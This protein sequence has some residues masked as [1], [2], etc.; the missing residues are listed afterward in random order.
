MQIVSAIVAWYTPWRCQEHL[1]LLL[2]TDI[3]WNGLQSS[4]SSNLLHTTP[5][6]I[7][8]GTIY[9]PSNCCCNSCNGHTVWQRDQISVVRGIDPTRQIISSISQTAFSYLSQHASGL[10]I[11]CCTMVCLL[12]REVSH[13][14]LCFLRGDQDLSSSFLEPKPTRRGDHSTNPH[15]QEH[16]VSITQTL[17]KFDHGQ[18][19]SILSTSRLSLPRTAKEVGDHCS[20][21]SIIQDEL[22]RFSFK[23]GLNLVGPV[24]V[25]VVELLTCIVHCA[26][27]K[28][29]EHEYA[30][31]KACGVSSFYDKLNHHSCSKPEATLQFIIN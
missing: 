7:V 20:I 29:P 17:Q 3:L 30:C 15:V 21:C 9:Q 19:G 14:H 26:R 1:P 5:V 11:K 24:V 6:G 18:F 2:S 8:P 27:M 13:L 23:L 25:T 4:V 22:C 28:S 12:I 16:A 31:D 10:P